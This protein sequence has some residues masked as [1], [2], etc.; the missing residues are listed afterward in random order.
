M[1]WASKAIEALQKGETVKIR[2]RGHSMTGRV[3]DGDLVTLEPCKTDPSKNDVVLAK[4]NG[5]V[6]LHLVYAVDHDRFQI[7]NNKNHINGWTGRACVYGVAV[8]VEP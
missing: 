1:G 6:Y 7:G 4:V 2:P 5:R 3:N 8:K